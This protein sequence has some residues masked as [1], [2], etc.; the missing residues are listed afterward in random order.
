MNFFF[1]DST[2]HFDSDGDYT[3]SELEASKDFSEDSNDSWDFSTFRRDMIQPGNDS[4]SEEEEKEE[5][6]DVYNSQPMR[7][8]LN[9]DFPMQQK[10]L[11]RPRKSGRMFQRLAHKYPIDPNELCDRLRLLISFQGAKII[12]HSN[13]IKEIFGEL[14]ERGI[15][16][17]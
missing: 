7:K 9:S 12:N 2:D 8:P 6:E 17:N 5:E 3:D 14:R 4:S 11:L 1:A 15:I 16:K 10:L 13:E